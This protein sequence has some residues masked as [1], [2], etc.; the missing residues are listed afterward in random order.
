MER[1]LYFSAA[2]W[3][4][5]GLLGG[6]FYREF[7]KFNDWTYPR[8]TQLSTVHTHALVLG[9][10]TF[11]I[12]LMLERTFKLSQASKDLGRFLPV[13]NISLGLTVGMQLIK[14]CLQVMGNPIADHA[15][16]AGMSGLG[17]IGLTIGFGLL[18]HGLGKAIKTPAPEL[19]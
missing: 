13:W 3:T 11:L 12:V 1:K 18:F 9:A 2:T 14:G 19:N 6:L 16:I 7:T 4:A 17:H 8:F 10:L 15:A 5:I